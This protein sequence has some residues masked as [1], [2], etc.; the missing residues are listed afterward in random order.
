M[1]PA[2]SLIFFTT[3]SGLGLGL[4]A[5]IG[6]GL[7]AGSRD[8]AFTMLAGHGLALVLTG[9]G[10]V[11]SLMHLGHPERAWRALSQWRSSW[12]SREGVLAAITLFVL[13]LHGVAIYAGIAATWLGYL[14]ALLA[15]ATVWSTAMIYA[16]LK[17]VARWHHPLTPWCYLLL[18]VAGG[19][20]LGHMLNQFIPARDQSAEL[21]AQSLVMPAMLSLLLA[22]AVK[23]VWW[24][25]AGAAGSGTSPEQAT[26]LGQL[27][28]VRLL[29][30]PHTEE[31]WLQQEMGFRIARRHAR[32]LARLALLLGLFVPLLLLVLNPLNGLLMVVVACLHTLGVMTERWL[33]F[34]EARHT[35]TLYYGDRH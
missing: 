2:W 15:L 10:L 25:K 1:R 24:I 35:V 34:A 19:L 8:S 4:A 21:M 28:K 5:L 33:F 6:L 20:V 26:G 9:A 27:G 16:S 31:N 11:S 17:T 13:F 22:A 12:L 32:K 29:M 23:T 30:P 7:F 14:L 18:A 3:L